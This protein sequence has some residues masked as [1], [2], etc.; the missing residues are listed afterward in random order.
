MIKQ[1][2][3]ALFACCL[4]TAA[5]SQDEN[6]KT[7][8]EVNQKALRSIPLKKLDKE[9]VIDQRTE[10]YWANGQKAT[11]TGRQA[12]G[13]TGGY[14]ALRKN[15]TV[16]VVSPSSSSISAYSKSI[17]EN[18]NIYKWENGQK[19][20]ITGFQA[21]GLGSGYSALKKDTNYRDKF[22]KTNTERKF[23]NNTS[24][25]ENRKIKLWPDGQKATKTGNEATPINGGYSSLGKRPIKN[26]QEQ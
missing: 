26:N 19:S 10:K 21:T 17:P 1:S 13:V 3:C 18:R 9:A 2:V 22:K 7:N 24:I 23:D 4:Y 12:T 8:N 15:K 6:N 11:P 14:S 25:I 16:K 20:T 5:I